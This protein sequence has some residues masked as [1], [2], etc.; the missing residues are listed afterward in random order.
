MSVAIVVF[1]GMIEQTVA[2]IVHAITNLDRPRIDTGAVI[3][4][5]VTADQHTTR[6][7]LTAHRGDRAISIAVAFGSCERRCVAI[8]VEPFRIAHLDVSRKSTRIRIVTIIAAA[9]GRH[10]AIPIGIG[11]R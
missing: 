5:I 7:G 3:I 8:L 1:G 11:G 6:S 4:A 2:I 10:A 9:I